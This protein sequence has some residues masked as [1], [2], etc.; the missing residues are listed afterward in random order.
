M[1]L[2]LTGEALQEAAAEWK[3]LESACLVDILQEMRADFFPK[4][5]DYTFED[6]ISVSSFYELDFKPNRDLVEYYQPI[7]G[8][9]R[10]PALSMFIGV[11]GCEQLVAILSAVLSEQLIVF[12]SEV[13]ALSLF[14]M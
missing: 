7:E 9:P 5:E 11:V 8:T 2:G 13:H 3:K 6:G 1:L 14:V 10:S 12:H 4:L